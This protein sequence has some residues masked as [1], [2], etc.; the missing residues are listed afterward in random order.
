MISC[1]DALNLIYEYLDGEL[2]DVPEDEVREHFEVC[3]QCFPHLK[4]EESFLAAVQRAS[5]GEIAPPELRS[6][7]MALL[8]EADEG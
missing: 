4:L 3:K 1:R 2:P 6:R 8:S 5:R 7:L